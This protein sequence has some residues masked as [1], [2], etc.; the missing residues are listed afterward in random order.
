MQHI[1]HAGALTSRAQTGE[2]PVE[3]MTIGKLGAV[4]MVTLDYRCQQLV[5]VTCNTEQVYDDHCIVL[6]Y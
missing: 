4:G 1:Q 2:E 3:A 6:L 5:Q